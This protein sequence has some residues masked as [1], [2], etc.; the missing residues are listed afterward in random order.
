MV[1]TFEQTSASVFCG[2]QLHRRS[3]CDTSGTRVDAGGGS[4]GSSSQE[5]RKRRAGTDDT[6]GFSVSESFLRS[7][8]S[9]RGVL[10]AERAWRPQPLCGIDSLTHGTAACARHP[11]SHLGCDGGRRGAAIAALLTCAMSVLGARLARAPHAQPRVDR[12][13]S[14]RGIAISIVDHSFDTS[15]PTTHSAASAA[16]AAVTASATAAAAI[17][18]RAI[19]AST[20]CSPAAVAA[21]TLSAVTIA[22]AVAATAVARAITS[23]AA[24]PSGA[25]TIAPTVAI[26]SAAAANPLCA[27]KGG[28]TV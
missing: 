16:T 17:S 20:A 24:Y 2:Q 11:R 12:G 25:P 27:G 28:A 21:A 26:A 1:G 15:T 6:C 18:T 22:T 23:S 5:S 19:T 13:G 9:S 14:V 4:A 3:S 8:A 10:V 7:G